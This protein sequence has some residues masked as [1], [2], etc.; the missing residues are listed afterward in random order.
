MLTTEFPDGVNQSY[1]ED[2]EHLRFANSINFLF[3]YYDKVKV[4]NGFQFR[5]KR[6]IN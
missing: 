1:S 5:N 4:G 6:K 3:N 2:P